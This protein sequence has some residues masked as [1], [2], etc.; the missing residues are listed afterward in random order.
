MQTYKA[1]KGLKRNKPLILTKIR[2]IFKTTFF[3]MLFITHVQQY[4]NIG[5][6]QNAIYNYKTQ[7]CMHVL[8]V[9]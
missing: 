6:N 2:D 5:K 8:S 9:R 7:K 1:F 3:F 4:P